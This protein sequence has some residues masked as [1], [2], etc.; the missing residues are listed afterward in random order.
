MF[1]AGKHSLQ[2]KS[3][4]DDHVSIFLPCASCC[5][6]VSL[7]LSISLIISDGAAPPPEV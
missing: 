4:P 1:Q 2:S 7:G 3:Q 6:A 5:M